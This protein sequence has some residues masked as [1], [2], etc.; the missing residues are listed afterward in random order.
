MF[1]C[2]LCFLVK[3]KSE[4]QSQKQSI[5]PTFLKNNQKYQKQSAKQQRDKFYDHSSHLAKEEASSEYQ[6]EK[7]T[8]KLKGFDQKEEILLSQ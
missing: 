8:I 3:E 4:N 7:K 6:L 5:H 1:V 2:L